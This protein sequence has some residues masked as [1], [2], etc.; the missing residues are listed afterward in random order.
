MPFNVLTELTAAALP[1]DTSLTAGPTISP[2]QGVQVEEAANVDADGGSMRVTQTAP[3]TEDGTTVV[4]VEYTDGA[5]VATTQDITLTGGFEVLQDE[6]VVFGADL[7]SFVLLTRA[8]NPSENP[9]VPEDFVSFEFVELAPT[10]TGG[11]DVVGTEPAL[12]PFAVVGD[13]VDAEIYALGDGRIGYTLGLPSDFGYSHGVIDPA[14]EDLIGDRLG[15]DVFGAGQIV[16]LDDG[17]LLLVE[18]NGGDEPGLARITQFDADGNV[19]AE[20]IIGRDVLT[21]AG[22]PFVADALLTSVIVND[23][24]ELEV[25]FTL[26]TLAATPDVRG[27][28]LD[29][30]PLV[31]EPPIEPPLPPVDPVMPTEG[32]DVLSLTTGD[33]V[34]DALG[35]NDTIKGLGGKDWIIGGD[36]DD[37][38]DGGRGDDALIP[39]DVPGED[40]AGGLYGGEGADSI[41]GR[42]GTDYIDGGAGNDDLRGGDGGDGAR[43]EG[44]QGVGGLYGGEG[45]DFIRGNRGQDDMFGGAGNDDMN[46]GFGDDYIEGGE[47]DDKVSGFDGA[48]EMYGGAGN[49]M[50][51]GGRGDDVMF[52]GEGD[53]VLRGADG[54]DQLWA[55]GGGADL[56]IG[57]DGADAFGTSG[58]AGEATVK[59]FT[60][61]TDVIASD[62]GIEFADIVISQDGKDALVQVGDS[63]LRLLKVDSSQL[64]EA[65]F[66]FLDPPVEPVE[67]I[68]PAEPVEP[69]VPA[70]PV[71]PEPVAEDL[72]LPPEESAVLIEEAA[73]EA[74]AA[75]PVEE[76]IELL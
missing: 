53:D 20:D 37:S 50:M 8:V 19:L 13:P 27:L 29:L 7:S 74:E 41:N 35:G 34:I 57:G 21:D 11:I 39:S 61:G 24:G 58:D 51:H 22:V 38:I 55:T 30:L 49:D 33:D 66:L 71:V 56:L 65:D 67:P 4:T 32:D 59:D 42:D 36:G 28:E 26:D 76:E 46:G 10:E 14:D 45:D 16:A 63:T 2:L 6:A 73:A 62:A 12:T 48:D 75:D 60:L 18:Q 64:S 9:L 44:A 3:G 23:E 40:P 43:S 31:A 72:F 68:V 54:A 1:A 15:G 25:L 52:G 17:G 70:E 5:G 69:I 47:G